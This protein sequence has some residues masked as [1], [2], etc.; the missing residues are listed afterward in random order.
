MSAR[1]PPRDGRA[2][3]GGARC[4]RRRRRRRRAW[5]GSRRRCR[6]GVVVAGGD[7]VL[8]RVRLVDAG[9]VAALELL[10]QAE[11][12]AVPPREAARRRRST[13][14]KWKSMRSPRWSCGSCVGS[15]TSSRKPV[16]FSRRRIVRS[17]TKSCCE[18]SMS[19]KR[20]LVRR[21]ERR[22]ARRVAGL[23]RVLGAVEADDAGLVVV[24][25][26]DARVVVLGGV[27][28]RVDAERARACRAASPTGRSPSRAWPGGSCRSRRSCSTR[29]RR[30]SRRAR[31]SGP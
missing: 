10:P 7:A 20:P 23:V 15:W 13:S 11:R 24:L 22:A 6:Y 26:D 2:T 14:S 4:R 29:R 19:L 16:Q 5:T 1:T 30:T 21:R 25:A 27:G 17:M 28:R 12:L 31:R 8:R 9:E 18:T 3:A